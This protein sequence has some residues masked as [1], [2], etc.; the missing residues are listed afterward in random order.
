MQELIKLYIKNIT[1]NHSY[2]NQNKEY[3]QICTGSQTDTKKKLHYKS[4]FYLPLV[5]NNEWK[6]SKAKK[7]E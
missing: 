3:V 7:T 1:L 6:Q 2:F 5:S 4:K